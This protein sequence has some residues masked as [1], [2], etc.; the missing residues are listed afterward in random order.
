MWAIFLI[1]DSDSEFFNLELSD[2][3]NLISKDFLNFKFDEDK[4]KNIVN[5]YIANAITPAKRQLY[6]WNRK[7][8]EKTGYL[9]TLTYE[10]DWEVIEKL[11]SSNSKLYDEYE[12]VV[13]K[14]EQESEGKLQGDVEESI[15]E[16]GEI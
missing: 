6:M 14:L 2:K 16:K 9:E 3:I 5:A 4:H 10:N 11:L 1:Y 13:K 15:T 7:M 8:D 12:R